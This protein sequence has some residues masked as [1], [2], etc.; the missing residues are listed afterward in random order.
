MT[1]PAAEEG[2]L[3]LQQEHQRAEAMHLLPEMPGEQRGN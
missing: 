3:T 1:G 2:N